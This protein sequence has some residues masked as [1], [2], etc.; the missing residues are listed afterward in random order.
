[1]K[2][3]KISLVLS[4]LLCMVFSC[5]RD[6]IDQ[7]FAAPDLKAGESVPVVINVSPS[8]GDDTEN[9]VTAFAEAMSYGPGNEVR[10]ADGVFHTDLIEV[11]NFCGSFTG[12]GKGKTIITTIDDLS[13]DETDTRNLYPLLLKFVGGNVTMSK[14]TITTPPGPLGNGAR[15]W[16]E[17]LVGFFGYSQYYE[18]AGRYINVVFDNVEIIGNTYNVGY[19]LMT[20][21]DSQWMDEGVPLSNIDI[22]ITNSYFSDCAWYGA[23]VM[24]IKEG[25]IIAGTHQNGN[26]FEKNPGRSLGIWHCTSVRAEV[27]DNVFFNPAGTGFGLEIYSS[28][29]PGF[30]EQVPQTF[31]SVYR[32]EQNEFNIS[33]GTG[34]ILINDNRRRFFPDELPIAVQVKNNRFNMSNNSFTGMGCINMSGMVIRNNMF[35]GTGSW[36]VRIFRQATVY[37]ENGLMLGNNFSNT[38]YSNATVLLDVGTRNWTI[39]GGNL[40]ESVRDYGVNNIITGFATSDSEVLLGETIVDNLEE[41]REGLKSLREK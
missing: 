15:D 23:C 6:D 10:L 26:I 5:S 29:Y 24:M 20:G 30:L 28:P 32:I 12:G 38:S 41:M 9:L 14:M 2:T 25:S 39:V 40:G 22:S 7:D 35:S 34:G 17:G 33:G 16:L 36:G 11:R 19:G 27:E 21:S 18:P 1:M 8:G 3:I 31:R 13:I 4:A 37:N